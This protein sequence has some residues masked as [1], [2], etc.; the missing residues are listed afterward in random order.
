MFADTS[1]GCY[2]QTQTPTPTKK[3]C[4]CISSEGKKDSITQLPDGVSSCG[5]WARQACGPGDPPVVGDSPYSCYQQTETPTP[6]PSCPYYDREPD[7]Q[8]WKDAK[9]LIGPEPPEPED[10]PDIPE[11]HPLISEIHTGPDTDRFIEIYNPTNDLMNL[12]DYFIIAHDV[13]L[14]FPSGVTVGPKQSFVLYEDDLRSGKAKYVRLSQPFEMEAGESAEGKSMAEKIGQS[15]RTDV[16]KS[17]T[18]FAVADFDTALCIKECQLYG[19]EGSACESQCTEIALKKK[20]SLGGFD[21]CLKDCLGMGV[22]LKSCNEECGKVPARP[23]PMDVKA[24]PDG[25]SVPRSGPNCEFVCPGEDIDPTSITVETDELPYEDIAPDSITYDGDCESRAREK[26]DQD[27]VVQI[28]ELE[29]RGATPK[30]K[31]PD[32]SK[33]VAQECASLTPTPRPEFPIIPDVGQAILMTTKKADDSEKALCPQKAMLGALQEVRDAARQGKSM[34]P[35]FNQVVSDACSPETAAALGLG[36][37]AGVSGGAGVPGEPQAPSLPSDYPG[38]QPKPTLTP[39]A[40]LSPS[41]C[42]STHPIMQTGSGV[43]C[44]NHPG[45]STAQRAYCCPSGASLSPSACPSTHPIMQTG[46]GVGCINHPGSSTAQRAYCCPRAG[47]GLT[48]SGCPSGYPIMQTSAAGTCVRHP[49]SGAAQIAYCCTGGGGGLTPGGCP[50]GYPI[51]QTGSG[52]GCV[53]HPG[54]GAAQIAYC[55]P[56]GG[57]S[58][59]QNQGSWTSPYQWTPSATGVFGLSSI[60]GRQ[61]QNIVGSTLGEDM[62]PRTSEEEEIEPSR[63]ACTMDVRMCPDG[64]YVSRSGPNCEFKPCNGEV[65]DVKPVPT[66]MPPIQPTP[67]QPEVIEWPVDV[68]LSTVPEP[69]AV[70]Q[71]TTEGASCADVPQDLTVVEIDGVLYY[72]VQTL[73]E[74]V[75]EQRSELFEARAQQLFEFCNE[76]L[77]SSS[78]AFNELPVDDAIA[79]MKSFSYSC[80]E[81]VIDQLHSDFPDLDFDLEPSDIEFEVSESAGGMAD[82]DYCTQVAQQ[83]ADNPESGA[84]NSAPESKASEFDYEGCKSDCMQYPE[85]QAGMIEKMFGTSQDDGVYDRA[86]CE[87]GCK[88]QAQKPKRRACP[89]DMKSCPD[90]SSV[91]RG[92][93]CQFK[94]CPS[95]IFDEV[96]DACMHPPAVQ[97]TCGTSTPAEATPTPPPNFVPPVLPPLPPGNIG[98]PIIPPEGGVI[99]IIDDGYGVVQ[100]VPPGWQQ[101]FEDVDVEDEFEEIPHDELPGM[102][103]LLDDLVEEAIADL[104]QQIIAVTEAGDAAQSQVGAVPPVGGV[105]GVAGVP[106]V[107]APG[108]GPPGF[109]GGIPGVIGAPPGVALEDVR[110]DIQDAVDEL[111]DELD[112]EQDKIREGP[113][114]KTG[115][116]LVFQNVEFGNA[117][118]RRSDAWDETD[119]VSEGGMFNMVGHKE[120]TEPWEDN[121]LQVPATDGILAAFQPEEK[122]FFAEIIDAIAPRK[123]HLIVTTISNSKVPFI[124]IYN[125]TDKEE[126][127]DNYIVLYAEKLPGN[128][129][130]RIW[131]ARLPMSILP[132][133]AEYVAALRSARKFKREYGKLPDA[134][135]AKYSDVIGVPSTTELRGIPQ[136]GSEGVVALVHWG[137][138]EEVPVEE[139]SV[140]GAQVADIAYKPVKPGPDFIPQDVPDSKFE[141]EVAYKPIKPGPDFIPPD[142]P[143]SKSKK[144]A[145]RILPVGGAQPIKLDGACDAGYSE[146]GRTTGIV[147][148]KKDCYQTGTTLCCQSAENLNDQPLDSIGGI[149]DTNIM[150]CEEAKNLQLVDFDGQLHYVVQQLMPEEEFNSRLEQAQQLL[151][152]GYGACETAGQAFFDSMAGGRLE[153]PSAAPQIVNLEDVVGQYDAIMNGC[154]QGVKQNVDSVLGVIGKLNIDG[155]TSSVSVGDEGE[156]DIQS[157]GGSSQIVIEEDPIAVVDGYAVLIKPFEGSFP[158]CGQQTDGGISGQP[159][160][161]VP[162]KSTG[163]QSYARNGDCKEGD[164]PEKPNDKSAGFGNEMSEP[165]D[166]TMEMQGSS[167]GVFF[168]KEPQK[169]AEDILKEL[170]QKAQDLIQKTQKYLGGGAQQPGGVPGA[171]PQPGL[172]QQGQQQVQNI[173]QMQQQVQNLAQQQL[174]NIQQMQA[175][176]LANDIDYNQLQPQGSAPT[177]YNQHTQEVTVPNPYQIQAT[178]Q[179]GQ[180]QYQWQATQTAGQSQYQW[181]A[182]PQYGGFNEQGQATGQYQWT[183]TGGSVVQN[184]LSGIARL[185][186]D[187]AKYKI[188]PLV[189]GT[190]NVTTPVFGGGIAGWFAKI[191]GMQAVDPSTATPPLLPPSEAAQAACNMNLPD[192]QYNGDELLNPNDFL[193]NM[194]EN[195]KDRKADENRKNR[196]YPYKNKQFEYE[197]TF[198]NDEIGKCPEQAQD[199]PGKNAQAKK[200]ADEAIKKA[201]EIMVKLKE[202]YDGDLVTA[203]NALNILSGGDP[204]ENVKDKQKNAGKD[205]KK[206]EQDFNKKYGDVKGADGKM[207]PKSPGAVSGEALAEFESLSGVDL[208][209]TVEQDQAFMQNYIASLPPEEQAKYAGVSDKLN[210]LS[211]YNNARSDY[212]TYGTDAG[213]AQLYA[214]DQSSQLGQQVD[215]LRVQ[216]AQARAAGDDEMSNAFEQQADAL[217]AQQNEWKAMEQRAKEGKLSKEDRQKMEEKKQKQLEEARKKKEEAEKFD[218]SKNADKYVGEVSRIE[219]DNIANL[220]AK[221]I[222]QLAEIKISRSCEHAAATAARALAEKSKEWFETREGFVLKTDAVLRESFE[223]IKA[224]MNPPPDENGKP[225]P[226]NRVAAL[227]E[228][229]N[230]YDKYVAIL[231]WVEAL[232]YEDVDITEKWAVTLGITVWNE[233]CCKP[234]KTA[235]GK[236]GSGYIT[237]F[238]FDERKVKEEE[239]KEGAPTEPEK[240]EVPTVTVK[241]SVP[242]KPCP[243]KLADAMNDNDGA[244]NRLN[245]AKK[246]V[247]DQAGSAVG[248]DLTSDSTEVTVGGQTFTSPEDLRAAYPGVAPAQAKRLFES[249]AEAQDTNRKLESTKADCGNI[250]KAEEVAEQPG[251]DVRKTITDCDDKLTELKRKKDGLDQNVKRQLDTLQRNY[252]FSLGAGETLTRDLLKSRLSSSDFK[253]LDSE[254]V[255][256]KLVNDFKALQS[257]PQEISSTQKE[258]DEAKSGATPSQAESGVKPSDAISISVPKPGETKVDECRRELKELKDKLAKETDVLGKALLEEDI[259]QKE[260]KC[261][262]MTVTDPCKDKKG[263]PED[264]AQK[265]FAKDKDGNQKYITGEVGEGIE[266]ID[267]HMKTVQSNLADDVKNCYDQANENLESFFKGGEGNDIR[268]QVLKE[269]YKSITDELRAGPAKFGTNSQVDISS[270]AR[271]AGSIAP[272]YDFNTGQFT[273]LSGNQLSIRQTD[274]A[275]GFFNQDGAFFGYFPQNQVGALKRL[276][277]D[278][279]H[280]ESAKRWSE[281]VGTAA[282]KE[283]LKK[284]AANAESGLQGTASVESNVDNVRIVMGINPKTGKFEFGQVPFSYNKKMPDGTCFASDGKMYKCEDIPSEWRD[285]VNQKEVQFAREMQAMHKSDLE[286]K[287]E[288][289]GED[290][291]SAEQKYGEQKGEATKG[292]TP[293]E[294]EK[295]DPCKGKT[296]EVAQ[297]KDG[298][299]E[300]VQPFIEGCKS[301]IAKAQA[302]V[303]RWTDQLSKAN[304][305][306]KPPIERQLMQANV[307]LENTMGTCAGRETEADVPQGRANVDASDPCFTKKKID[308]IKDQIKKTKSEIARII[309]DRAVNRAGLSS[310]AEDVF[311]DLVGSIWQILEKAGYSTEDMASALDDPVKLRDMLVKSGISLQD[312]TNIAMLYAKYS[313]IVQKERL[314]ARREQ[315]DAKIAKLSLKDC[316]QQLKDL[317]TQLSLEQTGEEAGTPLSISSEAGGEAGPTGGLITGAATTEVSTVERLQSQIEEKKKECESLAQNTQAQK[318]LAATRI[319]RAGMDMRFAESETRLQTQRENLVRTLLLDSGKSEAEVDNLM[320]EP[321]KAYQ[322]VTTVMTKLGIGPRQAS[323]VHEWFSTV[324][325]NT[326]LKQAEDILTSVGMGDLLNT[327]RNTDKKRGSNVYFNG[328]ELV[329]AYNDGTAIELFPEEKM[330]LKFAVG[331]YLFSQA[332]SSIPADLR[333]NYEN[334]KNTLERI[335]R[336]LV[337][338]SSLKFDDSMTHITPKDMDEL[339][340]LA[341]GLVPL[342]REAINR[343][344]TFAYQK[345]NNR[346]SSAWHKTWDESVTAAERKAAEADSEKYSALS[347]NTQFLISWADPKVAREQA[348]YAEANAFRS[349][350]SGNRQNIQGTVEQVLT[351]M[352]YAMSLYEAAYRGEIR[353]QIKSA[354]SSDPKN[355]GLTD[356]QLETMTEVEIRKPENQ[357]K[358]ASMVMA[359]VQRMLN[360]MKTWAEDPKTKDLYITRSQ[361]F[362]QVYTAVSSSILDSYRNT[363]KNQPSPRSMASWMQMASTYMQMQ[364]TQESFLQ[365]EFVNPDGVL[366]LLDFSR[367]QKGFEETIAGDAWKNFDNEIKQNSVVSGALQRFSTA[368]G[369]TWKEKFNSLTEADKA[370]IKGNKLYN[371]DTD[372]FSV[373]RF[374]S[375]NNNLKTFFNTRSEYSISAWDKLF[376]VGELGIFFISAGTASSLG[377]GLRAIPLYG[378]LADVG[379]KSMT[380]GQRFIYGGA[381]ASFIMLEGAAMHTSSNVMRGAAGETE[382]DWSPGTYGRMMLFASFANGYNFGANK[383]FTAIFKP[384]AE[385]S[386]RFAAETAL[387]ASHVAESTVIMPLY[388]WAESKWTGHDF[389]YA[390]NAVQNLIY[391]GLVKRGYGTFQKEFANNARNQRISEF[392]KMDQKFLQSAYESAVAER[393]LFESG[394][395]NDPANTRAERA[396]KLETEADIL[397]ASLN[398]RTRELKEASR[399]DS[400]MNTALEALRQQYD[401]AREAAL[402]A[403]MSALDPAAPNYPTEAARVREQMAQLDFDNA[404]AEYNYYKAIGDTAAA[405]AALSRVRQLGAE[406]HSATAAR[407]Q[408]E[409]AFASTIPEASA[410]RTV[411]DYLDKQERYN[412]AMYNLHKVLTDGGT[413]AAKRSAYNAAYDARRALLEQAKTIQSSAAERAIL[414]SQIAAGEAERAQVL[415][416]LAEGKPLPKRTTASEEQWKRIEEAPVVPTKP[417]EAPVP[418][419]A[420]EQ[421]ISQLYSD[422]NQFTRDLQTLENEL[423][424]QRRSLADAELELERARM[425]GTPEAESRAEQRI[426]EEQARLAELE[427]LIEKGNARINERLTELD[428]LTQPAPKPPTEREIVDPF[429]RRTHSEVEIQNAVDALLKSRDQGTIS[430]ADASALSAIEKYVRDELRIENSGLLSSI[431][432]PAQRESVFE[433]IVKTQLRDRIVKLVSESEKA[434]V[435]A[436]SETV[437]GVNIAGINSP[438]KGGIGGDLRLTFTFAGNDGRTRTLIVNGDAKGHLISAS[439]MKSVMSDIIRRLMSETQSPDPKVAASARDTLS[440]PEALRDLLHSAA[441]KY[442]KAGDYTT[443]SATVIDTAANTATISTAGE[444]VLIVSNGKVT[445]VESTYTGENQNVVSLGFPLTKPSTPATVTLKEGD[446]IIHLTDGIYEQR[447]GETQYDFLYKEGKL[448]E[449]S[450]LKKIIE[451]NAGKS[452]EEIRDSILKGTREFTKG[453]SRDDDITVNVIKIGEAPVT[454]GSME[455]PIDAPRKPIGSGVQAWAYEVEVGG[456]THVEKTYKPTPSGQRGYETESANLEKLKGLDGVPELLATYSQK[457]NQPLTIEIGGRQ[458]PVTEVRSILMTKA[459][460]VRLFELGLEEVPDWV[461]GR[462]KEIVTAAHERGVTHNDLHSENIFYDPAT[463]TVTV[464]DWGRPSEKSFE[465]SKVDD[466]AAIEKLRRE[467]AQKREW[468]GYEAKPEEETTIMPA[469]ERPSPIPIE[470]TSANVDRLASALQKE[471]ITSSDVQEYLDAFER[472]QVLAPDSGGYRVFEFLSRTFEVRTVE[473][474]AIIDQILKAAVVS[475]SGIEQQALRSPVRKSPSQQSFIDTAVSEIKSEFEA[476]GAVW[477]SNLEQAITTAV[478]DYVRTGAWNGESIAEELISNKVS[479]AK[480]KELTFSTLQKA[481]EAYEAVQVIQLQ[482]EVST[483]G[484]SAPTGGV[485]SELIGTNMKKTGLVVFGALAILI[486]GSLLLFRHPPKPQISDAKTDKELQHLSSRIEEFKKM[487]EKLK[488]K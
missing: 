21:A 250:K 194:R 33:Y 428:T 249:V 453:G 117:V 246:I 248:A 195:A 77:D 22:D 307:D 54:S 267:S 386:P 370:T 217:Q 351:R 482:P 406:V 282:L 202:F 44:I 242:E 43:G 244:Q 154:L 259:A 291:K 479:V 276:Y 68:P 185:D 49:G 31:A 239:K 234:C 292:M 260:K 60:T 192:C 283:C 375:V 350:S 66:L 56:G 401:A 14:Y 256:D 311:N 235:D 352:Q 46:S 171:Q 131:S 6:T 32:Y 139:L 24:C 390:T 200:D 87:V 218:P 320:K 262:S 93:D 145:H 97:F 454:R 431:K 198:T 363:L 418:P 137:S 373:S 72:V 323:Q 379:F 164:E 252:Q 284:A 36:S 426:K 48:P 481:Q 342:V 456:K 435:G 132:P 416:A 2:S 413:T 165:W 253:S 383:L 187:I 176:S 321:V 201:D 121:F 78:D 261:G 247:G 301:K 169:S 118:Q 59:I 136:V 266:N 84:K 300:A 344:G 196:A 142:A 460:G 222:Q 297:S 298:T 269:M 381:T 299:Y 141:K 434:S 127:L 193:K 470:Y 42:P 172:G 111:V 355:K 103:D 231:L 468:A 473:Q 38:Q 444:K 105:P 215:Q 50:Q 330:L 420:A 485:I 151:E 189:H 265:K 129:L 405:Q 371:P 124:K 206:A 389:D 19:G 82:E 20:P 345:I 8:D 225:Q 113:K 377:Q 183:A 207:Q 274:G 115:D 69:D 296:F 210:D 204:V 175:N 188:G 387:L 450:L 251:R 133:Q 271:Y 1:T 184:T 275:T 153:S 442:F 61:V 357:A 457:L 369:A 398:R 227:I 364:N 411:A 65:E 230:F 463:K 83:A 134:V 409:R 421:R 203:I 122:G 47:G 99:V 135:V 63:R 107:G 4:C 366:A 287:Q 5:E 88:E 432:D 254:G 264:I 394:L 3:G 408:A 102:E 75:F 290:L 422:I 92:P 378:R 143:D 173:Q 140:T 67:V 316:Q 34:M 180:S 168:C 407:I 263:I 208:K 459:P 488:E 255:I 429:Y 30:M 209:G 359:Q 94:K 23:C 158:D 15:G 52:S 278:R 228:L 70:A 219:D 37:A 449:N 40:P 441:R 191:T 384:F 324:A 45:S 126:N 220:K 417:V 178:S 447:V 224:L 79:A 404:R 130:K 353:S 325:T 9:I 358:I 480:A 361:Y 155:F 128:K 86:D 223:K 419:T 167:P 114:P 13:V 391:G 306:E 395:Q 95:D 294:A 308:Y 64:S 327:I 471:G 478:S 474:G 433:N 303:D 382:L 354:L 328:K 150:S 26:A 340:A 123:R 437:D 402:Q 469:L 285:C 461:F 229:F 28:Q 396:V 443:F 144:D 451:E 226:P 423:Y 475:L 312:S 16:I 108:I 238:D 484:S 163:G 455:V 53:R 257:L 100:P 152:E 116:V 281:S 367:A 211:S 313:Q 170:Q 472:N 177:W 483:V 400:E 146:A 465:Q 179:A 362:G 199:R 448:N 317:E 232:Y 368:P 11:Y 85:R 98:T 356:E 181:Q 286:R 96:F 412:N 89:M 10:I 182:T 258:C 17:F 159:V 318:D 341:P 277:S 25:S 397:Q 487:T 101:C 403:R 436:A 51:M 315:L 73:P 18:G 288:K 333:S 205:Y 337:A 430:S 273:D 62:L 174:Q 388:S 310:A 439:L 346:A 415:N 376:N 486:C 147:K 331:Q 156:C 314:D 304:A 268:N 334:A 410:Q 27:R 80:Q 112:E 197:Y 295:Y 393:R 270:D 335:K 385:V 76:Q 322:A 272:L 190:A 245:G 55:C 237:D 445:V 221:M 425:I 348:A 438:E 452:A 162:L 477:T 464:I 372:S 233:D 289:Y 161:I 349:L 125:P 302:E 166:D 280:A 243:E 57:W 293:S 279:V 120:A 58:P 157:G 160:D 7:E 319:E 332:S 106:G 392:S 39:G 214:S 241:P 240:P 458:I 326:A 71:V 466:F 236:P 110:E 446:I 216:A 149:T 41:G 427:S 329:A 186:R 309:V 380:W 12:D 365:N 29:S 213:A 138:E 347:R 440:N 305:A 212:A 462:V 81:K 338:R 339:S 336:T 476:Q 104:E 148:L 35:D 109:V 360:E 414:D 399:T 374:M 424:N 343:V 467:A 119:E 91:G 90:G 74:G